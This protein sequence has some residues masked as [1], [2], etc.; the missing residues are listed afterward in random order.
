MVQ[1]YAPQVLQALGQNRL[2]EEEN[3]RRAEASSINPLSVLAGALVGTLTGG[4]GLPT[5]LGGLSGAGSSMAEGGVGVA[6]G[7]LGGYQM[8]TNLKQ[9]L[10]EDTAKAQLKEAFTKNIADETQKQ[11]LST[12]LDLPGVGE[13]VLSEYAQGQFG[14]KKQPSVLELF[15][16]SAMGVIK[17]EDIKKYLAFPGALGSATKNN[18][19]IWEEVQ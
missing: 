16:L 13:K 8:G 18:A 6:K 5:L 11:V 12:A 19:D 15:L 4:F 1:S 14:Q 2:L 3:R 10:A 7:A 9:K 17:P